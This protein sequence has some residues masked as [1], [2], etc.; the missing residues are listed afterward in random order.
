[1]NKK[2]RKPLIAGNWKMNMLPSQAKPFAEELH[3]LLPKAKTCDIAICP[4]FVIIHA[5]RKA[6]EDNRVAVGAQNVSD[7]AA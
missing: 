2:Y 7:R 4:P 3:T 1:M 6:L 5:L